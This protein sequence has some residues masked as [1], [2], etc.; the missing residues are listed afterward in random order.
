M[1][2]PNTISAVLLTLPATT[3][4]P[5][6]FIISTIVVTDDNNDANYRVP[7]VIS[8][9]GGSGT[10][11]SI[12]QDPTLLDLSFNPSTS[13]LKTTN[14]SAS[15]HISGSTGSFSYLNGNS[16]L[17]IGGDSV[18]FSSSTVTVASGVS[19]DFGGNITS[20]G[21]LL[22]TSSANETPFL[23]EI[24]DGNGQNEKLSVNSDGVL[25][26]GS[27]DTLPTAVTGGIAYSSSNFYMGLE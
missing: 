20:S 5:I 6:K 24:N 4:F 10:A 17:I 8:Q 19:F 1:E 22:I 11:A 2:S 21:T 13:T 9:G 15:G 27:L 14:I 25:R 16:P 3:H 18:I 12:G 26:F 7:F 23:I